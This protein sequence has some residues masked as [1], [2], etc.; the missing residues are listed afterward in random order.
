LTDKKPKKNIRKMPVENP[1]WWMQRHLDQEFFP[2]NNSQKYFQSVMPM[3][4]LD[5]LSNSISAVAGIFSVSL[6]FCSGSFAGI[7]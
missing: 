5:F 2:N 3:I 4:S 6:H 7:H 1:D